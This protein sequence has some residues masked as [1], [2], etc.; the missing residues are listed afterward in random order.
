MLGNY[1]QVA[2]FLTCVWEVAGLNLGWDTNYSDVFH[3]FPH[4]LDA[5]AVKVPQLGYNHFL[6]HPFQFIIIYCHPT[7][8]CYTV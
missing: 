8:R 1:T 2:E 4:P 7:M 6:Q 5:K 3:C